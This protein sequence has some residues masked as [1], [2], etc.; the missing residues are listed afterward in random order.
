[1][2]KIIADRMLVDDDEL[3]FRDADAQ[4]KLENMIVQEK[5]NS[6]IAVMSQA[7]ATKEFDKFSEDKVDKWENVD[8]TIFTDGFIRLSDGT[9]RPSESARVYKIANKSYGKMKAYVATTSTDVIAIA[10]YN[11]DDISANGFMADKSVQFT[12]DA[13]RNG[14]WYE[15]KVPS[16]CKLICITT[17]NPTDTFEP[18]AMYTIDTMFKKVCSELHDVLIEENEKWGY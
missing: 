8:T 4:N 18:L 5:G 14:T 10:F 1:M 2:S 9:L 12:S 13:F 11:T 7:A 17:I 15:A 16:D 3:H 6:K